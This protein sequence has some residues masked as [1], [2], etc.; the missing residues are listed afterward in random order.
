MAVKEETAFMQKIMRQGKRLLGAAFSGSGSESGK[1]VIVR[2]PKEA[3][4]ID[5][6]AGAGVY[7]EY[8]RMLSEEGLLKQERRNTTVNDFYYGEKLRDR[9]VLLVGLGKNVR[10]SMQYILNELN[11]SEAFVGFHIYVRTS[12]ETDL[13]VRN[14]IEE[15]HWDRTSTVPD[16]KKYSSLLETAKYLIT[17]V[18]FPEGWVKRPG[19]IYINIWHGTPLKKLGLSKNFKN[20]HKNGVVQKNFIDADYL[21]Y[22]NQYTRE[23]MLKS[24][25]VT[26]LTNAKLLMLGYPRTGGMLAATES[27]KEKV[28]RRL[29]PD[30]KKLYVYMPTFRDYL[31]TEASIAQSKTLLDYLEAG[32]SGEQILYVNLHHKING[33]INYDSYKR[34]RPFP[35]DVDSYQIMAASDALISD[36]SSVFFDYLALRK[37]IVLYVPDYERYR[38]ERGMY[39]GL[40]ELPFDQ[41]KTPAQVLEALNRGKQYDD[42]AAFREFCTYDT[43]WNAKN[44]CQLLLGNETG[45]QLETVGQ[46]RLPKVLIHS[47]WMTAGRE[48]E[49]LEELTHLYDREQY[50]IYFSCNQVLNVKESGA[51]PMLF[52]NPVIGSEGKLHMSSI[53]KIVKEQYLSGAN[54]FQDAMRYL[55]YDYALLPKRMFGNARFDVV[56]IYDCDDPEKI[57]GFSEMRATLMLFLQ[58]SVLDKIAAGES[59]LKDAVCY[60]AKRSSVIAVSSKEQKKHAAELLGRQYKSRISIITTAE[61]MDQA[62]RKAFKIRQR[63][64][65]GEKI[66]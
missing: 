50:G 55:R 41:A 25:Q 60:A 29:A 49:L 16:A 8:T 36:Y 37:Q 5:L 45:L 1:K 23:K 48:T 19:Q 57:L 30:Q 54:S 52:E 21:L 58:D 12:D 15:N 4:G 7:Q 65:M 2:A 43:P 46:N 51:Y 14:F 42:G 66:L 24:Y 44:L 40:E 13:L 38:K 64:H 34:I 56:M 39:M 32:L 31:S 10:G 6:A 53:G 3:P 22:P 62:V 9:T 28:R 26:Q 61:E 59:F 33:S 63:Y 18:Y 47:E 17:E 35:P 11:S 20:A 27:D